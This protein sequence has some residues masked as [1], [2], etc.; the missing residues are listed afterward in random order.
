MHTS[1]PLYCEVTP[2]T[3][4]RNTMIRIELNTHIYR[5]LT[6]VFEFVST[7]END[8]QWQ[9]GT[10]TSAQISAG[11][12]GAGT[13]F[14]VVGHLLGRRTEIVYQV[15]VFDPNKSYGFKSVSG[16]VDSHT[17]YTFEIAGGGTKINLSTQ[18]DPRDFFEAHGAIVVKK[19]RKEHKENLSMLK[20]VLEAHHITSA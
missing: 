13:L 2:S 15:T 17:L 4:E 9:Y 12:I 16:P 1:S 8:F 10:L 14:R 6:Q 3:Y 7:P 19:F 18:T 5:P 20:N 11:D